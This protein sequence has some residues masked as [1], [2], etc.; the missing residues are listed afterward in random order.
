[1]NLGR[2]TVIRSQGIGEIFLN[3]WEHAC[4]QADHFSFNN[5]KEIPFFKLLLELN[6]LQ[7]KYIANID[8]L[9]IFETILIRDV[10]LRNIKLMKTFEEITDLCDDLFAN[11]YIK[12]M[13]DAIINFY[14][15][16]DNVEFSFFDYGETRDLMDTILI[17]LE[18]FERQLDS[19]LDLLPFVMGKPIT[20][21]HVIKEDFLYQLAYR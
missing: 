20:S 9:A 11:G 21:K 8:E 16:M 17:K 18:N 1:M 3:E 15:Y 4:Y 13:T 5:L 14:K 6:A 12:N 2:R 10:Y 7:F 19:V